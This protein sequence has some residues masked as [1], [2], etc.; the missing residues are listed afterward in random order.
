MKIM[1]LQKVI[2]GLSGNWDINIPFCLTQMLLFLLIGWNLFINILRK[3]EMLRL[4]SLKSFPIRTGL[5]LNMQVLVVALLTS[6]VI[7]IAEAECLTVLRMI[8]GNMT[9]L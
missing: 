5:I 2:T 6:M 9:T 3:T 1:V 8:M 7:H 4:F